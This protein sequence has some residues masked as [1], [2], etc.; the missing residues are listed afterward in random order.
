MS[1]FPFIGIRK[2]R[3]EINGKCRAVE[4]LSW[5]QICGWH[6]LTESKD[7]RCTSGY[8]E[9]CRTQ[10]IFLWSEE[11]WYLVLWK[12]Y[13]H[14]QKAIM[15][16]TIPKIKHSILFY[17]WMYRRYQLYMYVRKCNTN[18]DLITEINVLPINTSFSYPWHL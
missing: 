6:I 13:Q 10:T 8:S 17:L 7:R 1:I 4:A 14:K 15:L 9:S 5:C 12:K 18:G 11:K 2:S 3:W 16:K